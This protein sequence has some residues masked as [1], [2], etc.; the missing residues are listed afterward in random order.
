MGYNPW[1][2]NCQG[3][4]ML[5]LETPR[6]LLR[7][8]KPDDLE[9][10][11]AYR[12]D[13]ENARYQGWDAPFSGQAGI[14]FIE[15]MMRQALGEPGS[16]YQVALERKADSRLIGDCALHF[17][18]N[19][20]QQVE[21]GFTLDRSAQRQGYGAEAVTRILRYL[22]DDLNYHRVIGICDAE[23]VRSA[24]L[25]E[26]VGMRREGYFIENFWLKGAW[27]SEYHYAILQRE[28]RARQASSA[29]P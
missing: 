3:G 21:I 29:T 1:L 25:L 7:P 23:N 13:P 2:V 27:T 10:F 8:F 20:P 11:V 15:E 28:W 24:R 18:D 4:M 6:L 12:S 26:R 17:L 22:F 19:A 9:S 14:R 16:W 5:R